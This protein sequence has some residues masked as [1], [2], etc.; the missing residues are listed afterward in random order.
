[1]AVIVLNVSEQNG[2]IYGRGEQI[3]E[4]K[5]NEVFENYFEELIYCMDRLAKLDKE[6]LKLAQSEKYIDLV[7]VLRCRSGC[8]GGDS[9]AQEKPAKTSKKS[10]NYVFPVKTRAKHQPQ[11]AY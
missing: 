8:R 9:G 4:V 3:Y 5:L 7:G 6:V 2:R 10:K 11:I 1:M